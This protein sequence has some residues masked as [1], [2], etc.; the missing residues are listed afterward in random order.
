M[1]NK[2]SNIKMITYKI[3]NNKIIRN[4]NNLLK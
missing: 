3:M 1:N 2:T 4:I